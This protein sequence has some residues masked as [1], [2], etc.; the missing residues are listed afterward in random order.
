MSRARRRELRLGCRC[1]DCVEDRQGSIGDWKL[2]EVEIQRISDER[3]AGSSS[4][5]QVLEKEKEAKDAKGSIRSLDAVD[6]AAKSKSDSRG[7]KVKVK[8]THADTLTEVG[9]TIR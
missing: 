6:Q 8:T 2:G 7:V 1:E 4:V 9:T 3:S 5:A